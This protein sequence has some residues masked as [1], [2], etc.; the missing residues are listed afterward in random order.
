[1]INK[2]AIKNVPDKP[3]VYLWKDK[4]NQIIYIGK[5]KSLAKRMAQYFDKNMLNSYK[6]PKMLEKIASFDTIV[7]DSDRE[8]FILERQLIAKYRPFYNV[9][10]PSQNTFPYIRVKLVNNELKIEIKNNYKKQKNAI[11]YG[12][13]PNNKNFKPLLTY[14]HHLLLAKDGLIIQKQTKEFAFEAFNKAKEIMKFGLSFKKELEKKIE[15]ANNDLRFEYSKFYNDILELLNYNQQD[16]NIFIKLTKS[17]DV[18]SFLEKDNLMVICIMSYRFGALVSQSDYVFEIKL[19]K[20]D[21]INEFLNEFYLNN[22]LVDE[23]ILNKEFKDYDLDLKNNIVFNESSLYID[24][25]NKANNNVLNNLENKIAKF[26][27]D[28]SRNYEAQNKLSLYLKTNTNLIVMFDNSFLKGTNQIIGGAIAYKEGQAFKKMYRYYN[29][30]NDFNKNGDI[31]YIYQSALNY[32]RE[33][34]DIDVIF[35]DG[36]ILQINEIKKAQKILNLDIP[37]FGLI[38]NEKHETRSLINEKNIEIKIDDRDVFD[39]LARLQT[40]VDKFVKSRYHSKHL[41]TMLNNPLLKLKGIGKKSI[42]KLLD[43]FKS[44]EAINNADYSEL[45][46]V[47]PK[48]VA[49]IIIEN[50]N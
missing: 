4:N 23:I 22:D 32:L 28:Q 18:F 49:K 39:F 14:L 50:K 3:G 10:F 29:L 40:E 43:H 15:E 25:L 35:A 30:D 9:L 5:A 48:N 20:Q 16:Q 42:E 17:I 13:L 19:S 6:T 31:N 2:E 37:V 11:Y 44:Y 33:F 36:N 38:K 41:N 7:L 34:K 1:M 45:I 46:K 24:L 21:F 47:I 8:A 12:P 27:L 26:N